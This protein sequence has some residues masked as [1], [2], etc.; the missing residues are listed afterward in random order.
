MR[1]WLRW[2]VGGACIAVAVIAGIAYALGSSFISSANRPVSMP[3]DFANPVAIPADGHAVAASLR[4]LGPGSPVVLLLH[5]MRG[6]RRSTLPRARRLVAAGFSVL[7]IDQQAH[8]ETPGDHI[9]FGWRESADVH[10]ALAWIRARLPGRRIGVIGV[11]LGGASFQLQA[12][13]AH[14]DALVLEAVHP[15]LR[16]ATRNRVGRW[17]TPLLLAQIG[18]R[19]GV[20]VEQL[21][22]VR[23]IADVA[24]PVLVVGGERDGDTT[25]ADTRALY[26]AAR[27]PKELWIVPGA[28]HEDFSKVAPA[29]YDARVVAFLRRYLSHPPREFPRLPRSP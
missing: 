13:P 26:D 18:P 16:R 8:G 10:A 5:G 20:S 14:V 28:A 4:D 27:P 3:A 7:M 2:L 11:S 12:Q 29:G 23:H 6:D 9:T 21:D 22:P 24:T 17:M 15:D 25:A 19:L 1:R